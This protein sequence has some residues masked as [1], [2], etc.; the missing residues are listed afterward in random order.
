VTNHGFLAIDLGSDER[1]TLAGALSTAS[2]GVPIPGRRPPPENWHITLRFLGECSELQTDRI[3]HELSE[4][5]VTTSERVWCTGLGAF[6]RPSK[7][8][9][10]YVTIEDPTEILGYL[11]AVCDEAAMDV[12]LPHED[13]PHVPHLTLSRLRPAGD[14]RALFAGFNEFRVPVDV[15]GITLFRSHRTREGVRYDV[16]DRLEFR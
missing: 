10:V 8:G 11:A 16:V 14:V 15:G 12:G 3:M 13:R 6:P 5:V 9:V 1:H 4:M 2:S 7:A